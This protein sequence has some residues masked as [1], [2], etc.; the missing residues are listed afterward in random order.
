MRHLTQQL[1]RWFG[2]SKTDHVPARPKPLVLALEP[3]IMYDASVATIGSHAEAAHHANDPHAFTG[4]QQPMLAEQ[5]RIQQ[6]MRAEQ[7]APAGVQQPLIA[8]ESPQQLSRTPK[9]TTS[10]DH[11][12]TATTSPADNDGGS[13]STPST[14][15]TGEKQVVFIDG[16]VSDYQALVAGLPPGTEW[17]LLDPSKDGFAQ[18]ANYLKDHHGLDAIQLISH[19]AEGELQAGSTWLNNADL[20]T[21]APELQQIGNALKVGGDFLIYGCE[22]GKG[23]DG[24]LLTEAISIITHSNVAA[25]DHLVGSAAQ[26]GSWVLD[27]GF[28]TVTTPEIFSAASEAAYGYL[29]STHLEDYT[30]NPTFDTNSGVTSFN[31]DGI[32]YAITGLNGP[33]EEWV[34]NDPNFTGAG[35]V[36]SDSESL[37]FDKLSNA[38]MSS[39][40]I[41]LVNG[42]AFSLTRLDLDLQAGSTTTAFTI[43]P[44]SNAGK[45]ISYNDPTPNDYFTGNV[46]S[47]PSAYSGFISNANPNN[48][49]GIHSFSISGTNLSLSIGAIAYIDPLPPPVLTKGGG[50][51]GFTEADP[52]GS[53]TAVVIDSGITA[54]DSTATN[55]SSA[56]VT[57][58]NFS[59]GDVLAFSNTSASTYGDITASY[60]GSGTLTMTS[61][62]GATTAQWQA[63]LDAVTYK[64]TT[65]LPSTTTRNI[66][67][68]LTN[69]FSTST[70][71][72]ETVAVT[73]TDQTPVATTT[74][75][76]TAFTAG[77]NTASTPVVIDSGVTATDTDNTTLFGAT[78]SITGGFHSSEDV[79]SFTNDG[80]TMG[81]IAGSYN[82]GTGVLTLASAGGTATIAQWDH[83]LEAVKYTDTAVTPNTASRT[84]SFAVNDGT[85]TSTA[86]TKTVTVAD[87]DQS[88]IATT[89]G[90]TTAFTEALTGASTPVAVD[91]G[92]TVSD[93]DNATLASATVSIT[94]GFH[95]SEDVLAFTNNGSTMGNITASYNSATGVMTLTSAGA[96]ATKAQ[97][98]SA[99][100]SVTYTDSVT[101]P[102]VPNTT[103]RTISFA[104]N[105]GTKTGPTSTKTVSVTASDIAP[106]V[107]TSGGSAAFVAGDNVASTPVAIDSGITLTDADN[108]TQASASVA[109]TGNFHS[110]EDVLAFTN[111]GSTMGNI[112]GVYNSGTGVLTLTSASATATLAQWQA[113][114]RSVTYT[115]TAVTPNNATRTISFTSNDGTRN[116]ATVTRT[117]TVTDTDQTP[118]ATTSGGT[119][120][121]TQADS[122]VSTPIAIDSGLNVSDLD[123]TT[124]ASASVAITGNFHSGE[125]VLAF[126]NDGSTMGN[127]TASYNS[128][129]GV[130]TLTSAGATATVAQW[131]AAL[132]SVT[133]TDTTTQPSLPNTS[134]R[135]ISFAVSDGTKTS[136]TTTKTVLVTAPD[137]APILTASGGSAAFVAGDNVASTPV[138]IDGGITLTDADN[139]TQ[140]SATVAITGNFHSGEDVLAFTNDGST[141]GNISASYNASTGVLTLTSASA[142]ATLAQW[143]SALRSI[144]YTDTAV[145][146][147]NATRTISFTSNDGVKNSTTVTRTVTVT[148]TDQTPILATSGGSTSFTAGDNVASTPVAVDSGVTVSDL[149][150]AT[151]ASA[152]VAITG[153]LRNGEDV[154]AFTNN[155]ATMGNIA[156]SYNSTTGVMTLTSAGA[157]ATVGQWQAALR[158]ITYT[159]SAITPN[160]A[161]R[162]ISFSVSDGTETSAVGTKSVTVADVDQ[163]PILTTTAGS[164]HFTQANSGPSTPVAVDPG[165]G[166]TDRDNT[167]QA[168][169]TVAITGNF[170]AGEDVLS[171]INTSAVQFG[172]IVGSY[173]AATGVL[174]LTSSGATATNTQWS[175]ALQAITYADTSAGIANGATRTVSFT[176]N[177]GTKNSAVGTRNVQVTPTDQAPV[178]TASAGTTAFTA[179]DNVA[180]TPVAIDTGI[181]VT[182]ADNTTQA[183]ATVAVTG[184]FHSGEDVLAFTNDGATMGNITASYNSGTGVLTLTSASATATDAQWQAALRAVTYTDTAVTPNNSNR[185][186]SFTVN[187]GTKNSA[188]VTKVV[189]VTDTD[190]T[191]I[192]TTS[193]GATAF[194][195]NVAG[196]ATPVAIDAGLT[197]SD[198]DNTTLASATVSIT[199]GFHSS[200]DVLAFTNN[201]ATMGNISAS[202]NA[203]TGVMTLT[204][205]GA[206]ATVTQWQA[207]LASITYDDTV[208]P[209]NTATRTISFTINDG[210]KTSAV[211]TKSVTVATGIPA[212]KPVLTTTNGASAFV[213]SPNGNTPPI[214]VDGGITVSDAG[215]STLAA[216]AINISGNLTA[217]EDVLGFA[218]DASRM[219]D[220]TGSYNAGNGTLMLSSASG[221]ATLA[222]WQAALEAVT[223]TDTAV[224]PNTASRTISFVVNDGFISSAYASKL[225]TVTHT[226]QAPQLTTSAGT[227]AFVEAPSG[228]STGVVVDSGITVSDADSPTLA[229]ATV[230]VSSNFH[231]GEDVLALNGSFGNITA[232]YNAATGVLTMS[233]AGDTA[234]V[235]QWQAA[236]AAVTYTDTA[237]APDTTTRGIS[238]QVNDGAVSS[239]VAS[240]SVSVTATNQGPVLTASSSKSQFTQG[241]NAPGSAVAVD[242]GILVT[243]RGTATLASATVSITG[244]FHAGEDVLALNGSF[245]NIVGSYNSSTGVLTLTSAGGT[246]TLAQWQSA[247]ESVTYADRA[248]IPATGDRTVSFSANDG[249]V[250][251]TTVGKVVS[252]VDVD[253]SPVVTTSG[254][255]SL[256]ISSG[257]TGTPVI[258]DGGITLSDADNTTLA[259]ATVSVSANFHAGEDVLS[260]AGG[261][262]N[263]TGHYDAASGT[264]TLTS[265]GATATVAQWQ[266]ALRSVTYTDTAA[267][268]NIGGRLI[269]FV[270]NDGTKNSLAASRSLGIL[271]T[272]HIPSDP[273]PA[274]P[275]PT[276]STPFGG[277]ADAPPPPSVIVST[278][279]QGPGIP[280]PA[281][282]TFGSGDVPSFTDA[283][284]S[285]TFGGFGNG[286]GATSAPVTASNSTTFDGHAATALVQNA[287]ASDLVFAERSTPAFSQL[288]A[289]SAA[290]DVIA[291][292]DGDTI[293]VNASQSIR[294]ALPVGDFVR[295]D[296]DN[297]VTTDLKLADGRPLPPW[298]HF[299]PVRGVL[300]GQAPKGWSQALQIEI[301]SHDG[302]GHQ[303]HNE[304]KLRFEGTQRANTPAH[305]AKL[306]L[307]AQ[308]DQHG[309]RAQQQ[310]LATLVKHANERANLAEA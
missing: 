224:N 160:Q 59:T 207:A 138:V 143:Q 156:A 195:G 248:T 66:T 232:S 135:T 132:D 300:T 117:V 222:Q 196:P 290:A 120:H 228:P 73:H 110:G 32:H 209:P 101:Q 81:N 16:G 202:Y 170:Q 33:Y 255:A 126:T 278:G 163:T 307:N 7:A 107:T 113:A 49:V 252:V 260:F 193:S 305:P 270:V 284:H 175:N 150:N 72:S 40:T 293:E 129:T 233:S 28:G 98:Q 37:A 258:V 4:I 104:L 236:L 35:G 100:D 275:P 181:T 213:E 239:A 296:P 215:S 153:N 70:A 208:Q 303:A 148:D 43:T 251:S 30:S 259:S 3:R 69:A 112:A 287:L 39:V 127:I 231:S 29:L 220:I 274:D 144:T 172:N 266:A 86:A 122:G 146:P 309:H 77:D 161:T 79:L 180:S 109:I 133:Y 22:V 164:S 56:A 299:D 65:A 67:F 106:V 238:F 264:L 24:H 147:N 17:V 54:T 157:T 166:V 200:E 219:G 245:G 267:L 283:G 291:L 20:N 271:F 192:A 257:G 119:S 186:I 168:N 188:T 71:I 47:V 78:V 94:G 105:D 75:G 23:T 197:L 254:G 97:W 256:F 211:A 249:K 123:N 141:M 155:P 102:S 297:P 48:F 149:D 169:A 237:G 5:T 18:M 9:A 247:L 14:T 173:N 57:I 52:V 310:R 93:L 184:N 280:P 306:A 263:I 114:L 92:L 203:G 171:Y 44:D 167:T 111:D 276:P 99:L 61:A 152:T 136:A 272:P 191:P 176:I 25:A 62:G 137:S 273:T 19:G 235:A 45:A 198:R 281:T 212:I 140:A 246:A 214:V 298:L 189:S 53:S 108:T 302:R 128:G 253:Q 241:D 242:G 55:E 221:K 34:Q 76:S 185:T 1:R 159:D 194:V 178:A 12:G 229:S 103:N 88:P 124:L 85:K 190:Q 201:P 46:F 80:S 244:N 301:V 158:S 50:N 277:S 121:F 11:S 60:N 218:A 210:T 139:T 95:S 51:S 183:S 240:K 131:K 230:A 134:N 182:D 84:I 2:A 125:D 21:Y 13:K 26:G 279:D 269:S 83:A 6:T 265:A 308:M 8:E 286:A 250:A 206:T 87:T 58:S 268:P 41:S 216:A 151:L 154:L 217:G 243:D 10:P 174:T 42:D 31:L 204:S 116:S 64:N 115:D 27:T 262:G 304:V 15:N 179:G 288:T 82:S 91:S 261:A 38:N 227:T 199:G 162:T 226:P 90:G 89:S 142:S 68:T 285:P 74:G 294:V 282:V 289:V 223:Y 145:T 177:D 63:A 36:P 225:V 165:I 234:T 295:N 292:Q 96:T 118:I 130:M 205:A 187:D